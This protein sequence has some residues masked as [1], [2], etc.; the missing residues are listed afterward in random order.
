LRERSFVLRLDMEKAC[1]IAGELTWH[2]AGRGEI[3]AN[4]M[5]FGDVVLARKDVRTSYHL[6]VTVDDALQGITLVTRGE[7]LFAS[8]HIHI[9]LQALLGFKT[10]EYHHHKLL[11][12][13]SGK[14][15][16]KRDNAVTLRFLR[17][18]GKSAGE[19]RGMVGF[20]LSI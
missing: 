10:P 16:A 20:L 4:P 2:D 9:L 8:T 5:I 3:P 6:S 19:V 14:R 15:Y 18:S 13:S 17:E 1:A 12:D 11:L 7:D